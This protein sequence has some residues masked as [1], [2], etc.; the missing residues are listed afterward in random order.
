MHVSRDIPA[1]PHERL[2]RV[3]AEA[4]LVVYEEPLSKS[5]QR[6]L[7]LQSRAALLPWRAPRGRIPR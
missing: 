7:G 5:V 4:E 2:A 3:V 1:E 6:P